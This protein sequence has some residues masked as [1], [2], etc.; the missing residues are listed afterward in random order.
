MLVAFVA[1]SVIPWR[2]SL[3]STGGTKGAGTKGAQRQALN[4]RPTI[5][6]GPFA[7]VGP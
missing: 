2:R 5:T 4:S 6:N 1:F 3:R 7:I